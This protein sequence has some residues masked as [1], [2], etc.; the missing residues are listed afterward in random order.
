MSATDIAKEPV[1]TPE[2]GSGFALWLQQA[3][4][5]FRI[6]FR[7]A[8]FSRSAFTI[9]ALASMP[10]LVYSISAYESI[11][12]AESVFGGIEDARRIFGQVFSTLILG[13]VIYLG[14]AS[15]FITLF[16][17]E[18]LA[19]SIHY[20]LLA[21]VRREVLVAGKFLAGVAAT[22]ILFTACIVLCILLLYLPFGMGQLVTDITT[23]VAVQQLAQYVGITLL[24][25]LGYGSV[26]MVAGLLFRNPII[27]IVLI[28]GWEFLH[29]ILPPWLKMFSIIHYLKG[30]LP[31]P[32]DEGPLAV[33]V[34]PPPLWVSIVGMLMLSSAML[35]VSIYLLK[36]L[37]VHYTDE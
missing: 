6:E 26:F 9:Y 19:R 10:L 20:Y 18:I 13:G 35:G 5:I 12:D 15:L 1:I 21:P 22:L 8:L 3:M 14:S 30:L 16:R 32:I 29:F 2:L 7:K 31:I 34:A 37:E 28:S 23:G 27:P 4:A 33:I 36:K 25:V 24:A 17:G 11:Q